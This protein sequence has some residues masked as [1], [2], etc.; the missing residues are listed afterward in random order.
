MKEE[1]DNNYFVEMNTDVF[2]QEVTSFEK[3][4]LFSTLMCRIEKQEN[5]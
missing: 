1:F 3:L 4:S 2:S 5:L